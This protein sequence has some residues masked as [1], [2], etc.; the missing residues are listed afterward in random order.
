MNLTKEVKD[1]CTDKFKMLLKEIEDDANKWKD[2]PCSWIRRIDIVKMSILPQAIY[3]IDAIP[4]KIS[5]TYFHRD[6]TKCSKMYIEPH[7][8]LTKQSDSEQ[9]GKRGFLYTLCFHAM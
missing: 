5:R 8:T 9:K 3:R 1:L 2:I 6:R 7:K 4:I